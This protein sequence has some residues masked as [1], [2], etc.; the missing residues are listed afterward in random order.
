MLKDHIKNKILDE[1]IL[2]PTKGQADLI[3]KLAA[4]ILSDDPNAIFLVKGYAGTGKTTIISALVKA[5]RDF[6]I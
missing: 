1:L 5:F 6:K 4:F 3:D 2:N